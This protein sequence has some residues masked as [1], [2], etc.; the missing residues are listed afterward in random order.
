MEEPQHLWVVLR[1]CDRVSLSSDRIV[2][3][4]DCVAHCLKSL[5]TTLKQ[6]SVMPW[7]LKIIDDASSQETRD[8]IARTADMADITWLEPREDQALNSRQR[9]RYSVA[10]AYEYI[11]S[12]PQQDLVYIVEDDYLHYHNSLEIML[13]AWKHFSSWFTDKHIGIYPQ[14]FQQLHASPFNEFNDTYVRPCI[15]MIGP[16]RYYRTTWYTQETFLLQASVF[17]EYRQGFDSLLTIGDD[18]SL[19]EGNTISNVWQQPNVMMLMPMPTIA[20]H[21]SQ[22]RDIPFYCRDLDRLWQ[23]NQPS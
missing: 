16:D 18:T 10:R 3:K 6:N 22:S 13:L 2:P 5:V 14:D 9:S 17:H 23:D 15:T 4:P 11:Y 20:L 12:L 21:V 7:T 8:V 1:T 19:W